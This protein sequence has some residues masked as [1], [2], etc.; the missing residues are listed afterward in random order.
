M[1]YRVTQ[2]SHLLNSYIEMIRNMEAILEKYNN[3]W[4][5][6]I[7]C[8]KLM[9]NKTTNLPSFYSSLS[10]QNTILTFVDHIVFM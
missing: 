6:K 2:F 7:T 5:T 3:Y 4:Y 8:I 9:L 1:L 10:M